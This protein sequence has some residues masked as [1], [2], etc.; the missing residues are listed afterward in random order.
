MKTGLP[1]WSY[2]DQFY[3]EWEMFQ[4]KKKSCG[5]NQHTHYDE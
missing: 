5:E 2:L 1:I 4:E 3:L